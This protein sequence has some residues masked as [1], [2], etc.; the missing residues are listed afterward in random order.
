MIVADDLSIRYRSR[1]VRS[2]FVAVRGVTFDLAEGDF[3]GVV[4]ESGSGKSTLAATLALRGDAGSGDVS[5]P[6]ICGG[7]LTVDGTPVRGISA[8]RRDLLRLRIG[9]LAQDG[10]EKLDARLT[11]AE[12]V[13]EP[14]YS[15]DRRFSSREAGAAVAT[16]VDAMR[17]PLRVMS[18][19]PY[20]LS[21]GQR[22][23]VALAR[24][25]VL[26]P[27]LLIADEPTRGV[28]VTVRSGVLEALL[29]LRAERGFSAVIVSS[30][31]GVIE[32]CSERMLVLHRGNVV[33]LGPINGVLSDPVHPYL[34]ALA[35]SRFDTVGA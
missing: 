12:N 11:V 21:S 28:D 27:R 15:R 9:Y 34:K 24:A 25:L 14:I 2:R 10:A 7:S 26:E 1:D 17:L 23:R 32:Q 29:E 22:Q 33:G 16:I 30:D 18:R 13:A 5:A 4:G 35:A 31:L 20:E 8:H 3:L 6:R 19:F